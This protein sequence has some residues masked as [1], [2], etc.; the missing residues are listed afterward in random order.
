M[1][2]WTP[3]ESGIYQAPMFWFWR[4]Y[5]GKPPAV[6]MSCVPFFGGETQH[7]SYTHRYTTIEMASEKPGK[8]YTRFRMVDCAAVCP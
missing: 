8:W 7:D 5:S 4:K 2:S 6:E 3:K 1:L